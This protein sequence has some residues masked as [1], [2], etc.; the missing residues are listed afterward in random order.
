MSRMKKIHD[1]FVNEDRCRENAGL[2]LFGLLLSGMMMG[3]SAALIGAF[4]DWWLLTIWVPGIVGVYLSS[5]ALERTIK[6]ARWA[7][8]G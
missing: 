1:W 6:R 2:Y 4:Q 7:K 3:S 8:Q 5:S